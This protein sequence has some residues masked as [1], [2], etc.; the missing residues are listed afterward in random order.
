[1]TSMWPGLWAI[2]Y[3]ELLQLRRDRATRVVFLI[4]VIQMIV[5]GFAIDMDIRHIPTVVLD[6]DQSTES[7]RLVD[8]FANTLTFRIDEELHHIDEVRSR[9][10][11]GHTRVAIIVPEGFAA[12]RLR[13]GQATVQVL[14]DGSDSTVANNA[15]QASSLIGMV[16]SMR[17]AGIN[18]STRTVDV[19]PRM[20]YNPD[21]ISSHFYV[22]ALIGIIL[23]VVTV[24]L[25]SFSIVRERERGTLEQ[26]AVTPI[27]PA[28]LVVGKL[29]PYAAIGMV[30]TMFVLGLM[31][32]V[33]G[34]EVQG[35]LALLIGMSMLFLVPSLSLGILIST[36]ATNQ[37]E[38][39]QLALLIMLPSILLSG[40]AFPRDTMPLPIYLFGFLI[41]VTYFIQIL[42]G[43]ILRGAG[44]AHLWPQALALVV[45]AVG[46]LALSAARFRKRAA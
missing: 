16:Q 12:E 11:A 26:L 29:L 43:I 44:L 17:D 34:V 8:Q 46:L 36:A 19:R 35:S 1:M 4:P 15:M 37:A 40:F 6:L 24:M 2:V 42:R 27:S 23:Q 3:K 31:R 28:A 32:F 10:T 33:F 25:T 21:L 18:E 7:R 22:P 45:F 39:M 9:I 5:F 13:G 41:P 38:A 20:L 30:Q 14:V